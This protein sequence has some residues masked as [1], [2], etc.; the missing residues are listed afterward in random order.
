MKLEF[1]RQIFEKL[2]YNISWKSFQ[3]E[4]SCSMWTDGLDEAKR[5]FS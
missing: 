4:Q 3:W 2:K 1:S 5:H